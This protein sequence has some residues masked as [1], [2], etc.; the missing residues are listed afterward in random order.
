MYYVRRSGSLLPQEDWKE[1]YSDGYG[2]AKQYPPIFER[3]SPGGVE[4]YEDGYMAGFVDYANG[5]PD[6]LQELGIST[7]MFV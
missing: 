1:G 5:A 4:R 2:G 7:S 6:A 3:S